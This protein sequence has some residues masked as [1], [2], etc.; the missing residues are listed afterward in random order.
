MRNLVLGG[1]LAVTSA[2]D[3]IYAVVNPTPKPVV[4]IEQPK[5]VDVSVPTEEPGCS[6]CKPAVVD[7]VDLNAA[8]PI[9]TQTPGST[10]SFDEP[11]FAKP[12]QP[13][14]FQDL[15]RATDGPIGER[16]IVDVRELPFEFMLNA[17]RL[18]EGFSTRLFESTTGLREDSI[19]SGISEGRIKGLLEPTHNG[20]KPTDLGRRFLN[21]LQGAFLP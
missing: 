15:V 16:K 9:T 21:D 19:A 11:P 20:W 4:C 17:L 12:K 8:Y 10:V 7:V 13:K 1:L 2:T 3:V 18:N 14:A 5:P 6:K